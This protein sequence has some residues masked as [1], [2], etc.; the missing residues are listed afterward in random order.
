M[1]GRKKSTAWRCAGCWRDAREDVPATWWATFTCPAG[2]KWVWTICDGHKN[3]RAADNAAGRFPACPES[4]CPEL[5]ADV[6]FRA[7]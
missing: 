5:V 6:T 3:A 1:F 7:L 4:T 2:D